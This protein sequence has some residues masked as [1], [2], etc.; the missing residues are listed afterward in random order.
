[1]AFDYPVSLDVR[2][3]RCV[4]VGGNGLAEERARALLEAGAEVTVVAATLTDGLAELAAAGRVA[5]VARDYRAGDLDGA[6]L[7][8]GATFDADVNG[9]LWAEAETRGVLLNAV[10]D[11]PHCHFALPSVLRR[12]PLAVTVSTGGRSPALAR[13]IRR[14]LERRIGPE[15]G[16]LTDAVAE[17]RSDLQARRQI[18][19]GGVPTDFDSWSRRW[20]EALDGDLA[21]LV[22]EGRTDD[23]KAALRAAL[24][25]KEAVA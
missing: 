9:R 3:R 11:T 6:F 20:Q 18:G 22:R 7:A 8:I 17:V 13:R 14:D 2:G 16:E 4:V 10:D 12:G 25:S 1:M 5:H 19:D 15:Y 23:V 21:A 24:T